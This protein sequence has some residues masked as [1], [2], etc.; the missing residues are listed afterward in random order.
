MERVK[1]EALD[2]IT[3]CPKLRD[4]QINIYSSDLSLRGLAAC[5]NLERLTLN[6]ANA[7][8]VLPDL[9][10]LSVQELSL[11]GFG[12]IGALKGMVSVETLT[13]NT[14]W[15]R[16]GISELSEL[17]IQTLTMVQSGVG[18][19]YTFD[20]K[21]LEAFDDLHTFSMDEYAICDLSPLL[22][23]K[24]P[25]RIV[26]YIM[27]TET[28]TDVFADENKLV[29]PIVTVTEE[30]SSMIDGMDLRIPKEQLL[31]LIEKENVTLSFILRYQ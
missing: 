25:V 27:P 30:T 8:A 16:T 12:D 17:G 28:N 15:Y 5:K 21:G 14:K 26:L 24:Q 29:E 13:V 2:F 31:E 11:N 10:G 19:E 22:A 7:D 9:S 20:L 1:E 23:L 6:A 3:F 4:L 18:T